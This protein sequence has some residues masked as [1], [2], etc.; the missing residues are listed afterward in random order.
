M[1]IN[2][3]SGT[4]RFTQGRCGAHRSPVPLAPPQVPNIGVGVAVLPF[5]AEYVALDMRGYGSFIV[6]LHLIYEVDGAG[7]GAHERTPSLVGLPDAM[8]KDELR[9]GVRVACMY[10]T[11][12]DALAF[13]QEIVRCVGEAPHMFSE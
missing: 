3:G 8:L 9:R 11:L 13:A 7:R 4:L 12:A 1:I 6:P 2:D 5:S 10:L